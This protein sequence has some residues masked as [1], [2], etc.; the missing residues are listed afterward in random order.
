MWVRATVGSGS[1]ATVQAASA[2]ATAW[3]AV[4]C[5]TGDSLLDLPATR[6]LL[7]A[8]M[9]R[10]ETLIPKVEWAGYV[11]R[12]PDGNHR[13]IVDTTANNTCSSSSASPARPAGWTPVLLAHSHPALPGREICGPGREAALGPH[14][15]LLS[16]ADWDAADVR[17]PSLP[18]V[19]VVAIDPANIAI[20]RTGAW[21][22]VTGVR[23]DDGS[24][25]VG[26]RTPSRAPCDSAY[27]EFPRKEGTCVRP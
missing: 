12:L 13:F 8:V 14:G 20:G 11:H 26:R 27:S 6:A 19:P 17:H 24:G 22:R 3:P 1:T 15:G 25:Y 7:K 4:T 16:A 10:T 9:E 2:N 5:P 23:K 18:G 21:E